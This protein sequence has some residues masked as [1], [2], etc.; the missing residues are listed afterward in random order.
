MGNVTRRATLGIKAEPA[1]V[2]QS[3]QAKRLGGRR[4]GARWG[5]T[6]VDLQSLPYGSRAGAFY[7]HAPEVPV[8]THL[9]QLLVWPAAELSLTCNVTK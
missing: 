6:G 2:R 7:G 4:A 1:D 8:W 3:A 5:R 9:L